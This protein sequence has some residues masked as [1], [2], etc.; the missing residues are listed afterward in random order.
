M[1]RLTT[2]D[3]GGEEEEEDEVKGVGKEKMG[4]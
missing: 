1:L 2:T 4:E 3:D